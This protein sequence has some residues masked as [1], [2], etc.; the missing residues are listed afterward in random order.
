M[1]ARKIYMKVKLTLLALIITLLVS[2]QKEEKRYFAN[3][4]LKSIYTLKDGK[5]HGKHIE[6]YPSGAICIEANYVNGLLQGEMRTYY[7][8]GRLKILNHFLNDIAYDSQLFYNIYGG[9]DSVYSYVQVNE[10]YLNSRQ[11]SLLLKLIESCFDEKDTA[12]VEYVNTF[13]VY[14]KKGHVI[15]NKSHWFD[16]LVKSDTIQLSDSLLAYVYFPYGLFGRKNLY[17]LY[18]YPSKSKYNLRRIRASSGNI[19]FKVKPMHRGINYLNGFIDEY[20]PYGTDTLKAL[21]F[22][23]K[24]YYVK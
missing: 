10:K 18:F 8:N 1:S 19:S 17:E 22:F 11:S 21:L 23:S 5:R 3:G 14:D 4:K 7:E 6:Y 12:K 9:L 16:I 20:T 24:K 13:L 15:P 2:C